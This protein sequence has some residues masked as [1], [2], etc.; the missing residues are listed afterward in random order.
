MWIVIAPLPYDRKVVAAF[1]EQIDAAVV[2]R[3]RLRRNRRAR[4]ALTAMMMAVK[5]KSLVDRVT[6][7]WV[8]ATGRSVDLDGQPW[9][10]GPVGGADLIGDE[11]L[12]G[13]AARQ[14]ARLR[15]GGGLLASMAILDGDGF[16]STLLRPEIV[17]FY[18]H[19]SEWDMD[20]WSQWSPVA[21][22]FAW[23]LSGL[24]ARRLEQLS[25]PLRPLD[26]AHGMESRVVVAVTPA[27]EQVGA[28][29]LRTLRKTGQT[30]YSGWYGV[31]TLPGDAQPR[32]RIAFPLPNG[33][34]TV[35]LLPS[36]DTDGA[37]R[38]TSTPGD[39]GTDGAYLI[40]QR[41]RSGNAAVRRVPLHEQFRVY[42]DDRGTLRTDHSLHLGH[43][44]IIRL[45]YRLTRKSVP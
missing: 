25:L 20:V 13:E 21:W 12:A 1:E 28:A 18:E 22:P 10:R 11:W 43:V 38:L 26:A 44:P 33:S 36:V 31:V 29:W 4:C 15:E 35:Y 16:Q 24:F 30:V 6:Q 42:V 9:L 2:P 23:L 34:I 7:L 17:D 40:V 39:F 32:V 41:Q 45:H 3:C 27:D 37:L 19:T 8:L 14:E 5:R